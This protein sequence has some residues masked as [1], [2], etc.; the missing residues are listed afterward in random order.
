MHA[1]P[2]LDAQVEEVA[3]AVYGKRPSV[4]KLFSENNYVCRLDW[5]GFEP[6]VLKAAVAPHLHESVRTE[7]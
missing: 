4:T 6:A 1:T 7:A 3:T 5:D 2:E